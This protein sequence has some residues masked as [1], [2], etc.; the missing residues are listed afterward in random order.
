MSTTKI[1]IQAFT[2]IAEKQ[3]IAIYKVLTLTRMVDH[4]EG[5]AGQIAD[6]RLCLIADF[7][8]AVKSERWVSVN[9]YQALIDIDKLL[10]LTESHYQFVEDSD[11]LIR[12]LIDL[13]EDVPFWN[14]NP[15][16]REAK[17]ETLHLK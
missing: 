8:D 9:V 14:I 15:Q 10:L 11:R 2:K 13:N 17:I 6:A 1:M 4:E 3:L 7:L 16:E 5:S 12:F